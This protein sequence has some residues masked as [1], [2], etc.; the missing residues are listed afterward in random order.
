MSIPPN[1]WYTILSGDTLFGIAK[2]AKI[3]DWKLIYNHTNNEQFRKKNPDPNLIYPEQLSGYR[4]F[5]S[6]LAEKRFL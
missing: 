6:V 3:S 1:S 4:L 5:S 2:S